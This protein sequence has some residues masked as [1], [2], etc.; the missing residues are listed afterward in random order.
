MSHPKK[1]RRAVMAAA[2]AKATGTAAGFTA[3][4]LGADPETSMTIGAVVAGAVGDVLLQYVAN[5]DDP[6]VEPARPPLEPAEAGNASEAT[7]GI[8]PREHRR[9]HRGYARCVQRHGTPVT[10]AQ[11]APSPRPAAEPRHAGHRHLHRGAQRFVRR[12]HE[13]DAGLQEVEGRR[14]AS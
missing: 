2:A 10:M 13:R 9:G 8:R 14:G 5:A 4:A 3:H 6:A 11:P 12:L 1:R 7:A